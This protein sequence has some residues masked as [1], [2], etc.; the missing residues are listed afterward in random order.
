MQYADQEERR[1]VFWS[2]YILDKL[3]SCSR[4]RPS[5]IADAHCRVQLPCDELTFRNGEWK[6][7]PTLAQL[8]SSQVS[9]VEHPGN[10]SLVVLTASI[11]GRCAQNCIHESNRTDSQL[12]PWDSKSDF[13]TIYAALLQIETQFDMSRC[14]SEALRDDCTKDGIIDMQLAGPLIFYRI[15]FQTCHCLLCHPFL[16]YQQLRTKY[17]KPPPS[18]LNRT[19]QTSR[20]HGFATSRL[21]RDVRGMGCS[22]FYSFIGYC[23]TVASGIHA[24]FLNDSDLTISREARDCLQLDASF[25]EEFSE[26]WKCGIEMVCN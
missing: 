25:L 17:P 24:L 15:L 21:I 19:L 14:I 6:K 13:A 16:L 26:Y 5:V 10:L 3:C 7:M 9:V 1:R 4:A 23:T 20:E 18:F 12:P 22:I 11:L 2:I 8:L